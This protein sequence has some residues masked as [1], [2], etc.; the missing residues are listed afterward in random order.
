MPAAAPHLSCIRGSPPEGEHSR[1]HS[2]SA[3]SAVPMKTGPARRQSCETTG[4]TG[5]PS[6][7]CRIASAKSESNATR[8]NRSCSTPQAS[9]APGTETLVHPRSGNVVC[10]AARTASADSARGA[11][12]DAFRP[13]S[14]LPSHT[15][16]KASL[17]MPFD[18]GSTTVRVIAGRQCRIDRAAAGTQDREAGLRSQRLAR[19]DH[20]AGRQDH[21]ALRRVETGFQAHGDSRGSGIGMRILSRTGNRSYRGGPRPPGVFHADRAV[22]RSW[23]CRI[24]LR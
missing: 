24:T 14:V 16:A 3:G 8:P 9:G 1:A 19:R 12:P 18:V 7:A 21:T 5:N 2:S 11:G 22:D 4:E 20:P 15:I 17:P 13:C 10:P 6:S 23:K